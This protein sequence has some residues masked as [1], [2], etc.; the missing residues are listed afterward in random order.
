MA[1]LFN[2]VVIVMPIVII[3]MLAYL[4]WLARKTHKLKL[5]NISKTEGK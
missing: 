4:I 2:I 3:C 1:T 5:D